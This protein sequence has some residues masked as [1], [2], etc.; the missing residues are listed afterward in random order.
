MTCNPPCHPLHM[1]LCA[2][3]FANAGFDKDELDDLK[4]DI[5]GER[6]VWRVQGFAMT[7]PE[8]QLHC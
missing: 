2:A 8:C 3:D 4:C 1:F 5:L 6:V 7:S